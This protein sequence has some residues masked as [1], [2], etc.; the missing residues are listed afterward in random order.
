MKNL[1]KDLQE[2]FTV[3]YHDSHP[4]CVNEDFDGD[5]IVDYALLLRTKVKGKNVERVV[6][7]KGKIEQSFIPID[8]DDLKDRT[9]SFF[10]RYVP[11][12]K[13]KE[14]NTDKTIVISRPAFELVLFEAASRVYFW[15]ENELHFIQTSD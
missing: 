9:G 1:D 12:G 3:T 2:Y 7:L 14:W 5:G 10:I 8:L 11:P 6:V 4:G 15:Q 13:I